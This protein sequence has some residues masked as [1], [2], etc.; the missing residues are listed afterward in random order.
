MDILY[1][2]PNGFPCT[3]PQIHT[4]YSTNIMCRMHTYTVYAALCVKAE[5]VATKV[6]VWGKEWCGTKPYSFQSA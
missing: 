4:I 3:V 2:S 6:G 5:I 1:V